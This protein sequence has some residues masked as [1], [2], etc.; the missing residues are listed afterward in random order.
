MKR[1]NNPTNVKQ[2]ALEKLE[3]IVRIP[4]KFFSNLGTK[5]R[6]FGLIF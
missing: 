2:E 1:S 5:V 4:V 6:C 3:A